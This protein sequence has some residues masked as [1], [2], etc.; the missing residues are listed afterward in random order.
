MISFLIKRSDSCPG[1]ASQLGRPLTRLCGKP[2]KKRR[3]EGLQRSLF[4]PGRNLGTEASPEDDGPRG[5]AGAAHGVPPTGWGSS[6]R[7]R[8][9]RAACSLVSCAVTAQTH[10]CSHTPV[11]HVVVPGKAQDAPSCGQKCLSFPV[12]A[13]VLP[14]MS[15]C[16]LPPPPRLS[17]RV[18]RPL[19]GR[20]DSAKLGSRKHEF[21][22]L[23]LRG[24]ETRQRR[25]V[26]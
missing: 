14:A 18:Q 8:P 23:P 12:T 2:P 26:A 5:A 19:P 10:F 15:C 6:A 21:L 25:L 13:P 9:L 17:L 16:H 11:H 3:Q 1:G 20:K 22:G 4:P 24:D 7:G